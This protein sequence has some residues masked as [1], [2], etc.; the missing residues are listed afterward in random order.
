M[1]LAGG[2]RIPSF[3]SARTAGTADGSTLRRRAIWATT[4]HSGLASPRG[5]STASVH[6]A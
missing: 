1:A 6:T 3:P 4:H 5:V 2:S